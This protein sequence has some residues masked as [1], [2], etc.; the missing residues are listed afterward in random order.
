[1]KNFLCIRKKLEPLEAYVPAVLLSEAQFKDLGMNLRKKIS[2]FL[3]GKSFLLDFCARE[4]PIISQLQSNS[5][6]IYIFLRVLQWAI[7]SCIFE[8]EISRRN[9]MVSIQETSKQNTRMK[10]QST[11]G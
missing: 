3:T 11:Q 2:Q 8:S 1:M 6:N 4:R 10:A 5:V 9:H 7:A